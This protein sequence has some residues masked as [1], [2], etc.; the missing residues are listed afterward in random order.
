[1]SVDGCFD[2]SRCRQRLENCRNATFSPLVVGLDSSLRP[3]IP[4]L[5]CEVTWQLLHPVSI[6]SAHP[7]DCLTEDVKPFPLFFGLKVESVPSY[8]DS[9]GLSLRNGPR[10]ILLNQV[11][12]DVDEIAS[13]VLRSEQPTMLW[14]LT[15]LLPLA[16]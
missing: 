7:T 3:L 2:I 5:V 11:G 9:K 13:V 1:M 14:T 16:N 8:L 10:Y 4:C 15:A 6:H 12:T